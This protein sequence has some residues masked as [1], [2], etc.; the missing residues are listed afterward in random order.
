MK[1]TRAAV[2]AALR[3]IDF[4]FLAKSC[5]DKSYTIMQEIGISYLRNRSISYEIWYD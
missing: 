5:L 1:H 4:N 3:N 2:M